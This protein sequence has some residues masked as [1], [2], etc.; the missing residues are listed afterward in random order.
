MIKGMLQLLKDNKDLT[1]RKRLYIDMGCRG[2]WP[3]VRAQGAG[4]CATC[5][6]CDQ[7]AIAQASALVK[8]LGTH[9]QA[10]VWP[11]L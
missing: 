7:L 9:S 3:E 5:H 10:G 4:A 1:V 8:V 11:E 6:C 2:D